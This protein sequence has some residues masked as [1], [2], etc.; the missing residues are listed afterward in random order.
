VVGGYQRV[1][2]ILLMTFR[3]LKM[4]AVCSFE[5]LV[6]HLQGAEVGGSV[7][8]ETLVNHLQGAED[9]GSVFF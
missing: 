2:E 1:G 5:T 9:G 3:E 6:N 4:E 8:F 7:F